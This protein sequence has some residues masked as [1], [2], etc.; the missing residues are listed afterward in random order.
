[1]LQV[2][3]LIKNHDNAFELVFSYYVNVDVFTAAY[4]E[5]NVFYDLTTSTSHCH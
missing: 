2:M 3:L 5:I 4:S 1:M